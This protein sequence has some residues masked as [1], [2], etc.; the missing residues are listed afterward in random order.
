MKFFK[1]ANLAA[2]RMFSYCQMAQPTSELP[3]NTVKNMVGLNT[4][5]FLWSKDKDTNEIN[6]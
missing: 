4:T 2:S 3:E 5:T 1:L 6:F